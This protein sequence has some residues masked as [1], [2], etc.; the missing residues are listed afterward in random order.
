MPRAA[1]E[2]V[3]PPR[4][5][6]RPAPPRARRA[7]AVRRAAADRRR[8]RCRRGPARRETRRSASSPSATVDTSMPGRE[9]RARSRLIGRG[10]APVGHE[11]HEASRVSPRR[12]RAQPARPRARA[13]ARWPSTPEGRTRAETFG[14]RRR[15]VA[16]PERRH[17]DGAS[18]SKAITPTASV[19]GSD[20][21]T[22][23]DRLRAR[24]RSSA[25][26]RCGR[27]CCPTCRRRPRAP[28]PARAR[29]GGAG[30]RSG[31]AASSGSVSSSGGRLR[32][33]PSTNRPP[34]CVHVLGQRAALR[35]VE[36]RR[37]PRRRAPR[38]RT[39]ASAVA[40]RG[41][42]SGV[43]RLARGIRRATPPARARPRR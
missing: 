22:R 11:Q 43:V 26:R 28:G 14:E 42:C 2:R 6:P 34:P 4:A 23:C 39:A 5:R 31:S 27:P 16:G 30:D 35:V 19:G 7:P 33:A 3:R 13:R 29:R 36:T 41:V 9:R 25:R 20:A 8:G 32:G 1:P 17:V 15:V 18:A 38:R 40:V 21:S 10:G 37:C 24:T 12:R